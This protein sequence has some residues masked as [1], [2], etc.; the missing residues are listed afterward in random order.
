MEEDA[1][2]RGVTLQR[3]F[4][5]DAP[6]LKGDEERLRQVMMNLALDSLDAVGRGGWVRFVV[7]L[8]AAL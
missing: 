5:E 7:R 1:E 8:P 3:D 2:R 4:A 6:P